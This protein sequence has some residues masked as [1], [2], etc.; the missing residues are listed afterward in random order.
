MSAKYIYT[1]YK[2][3]NTVNNKIYIGVHKTLKNN[4]LDKSYWGSS[5]WLKN[6]IPKYGIEEFS[7][8]ILYIFKT[9]KE[10]FDKEEKIVNQE[11]IDREDTYNMALGGN[12][13]YKSSEKIHNN[14]NFIT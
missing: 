2:I 14:E 3:T 7:K 6:S 1:L 5:V 9:E 4:P 8:Q 12:G 13:R 10:A 11:F